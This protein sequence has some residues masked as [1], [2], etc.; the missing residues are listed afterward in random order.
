MLDHEQPPPMPVPPRPGR[1]VSPG[2]SRGGIIRCQVALLIREVLA[3]PLVR[4]EIRCG[5]ARRLSEY[6]GEPELA[7]AAHLN[8]WQDGG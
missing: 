3:D 5:L 6:P 7:L 1:Q 4:E 2:T 8:D